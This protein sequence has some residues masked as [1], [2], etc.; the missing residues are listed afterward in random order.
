[1]LAYG[2]GGRGRVYWLLLPAPRGGFFRETF[3]AVNAA[4]RRAAATA[5]R[6]ARLIDLE[7]VF[8]PGGRY[9]ATMRV[10]GRRV[11]VRQR[12]GVHLSAAGAALAA[13]IVAR[14]LRAERILP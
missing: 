4:L 11:R 3:P 14:T 7:R 13:R 6:Y 9:R 12:D 10:N 1:M 5:R 2:R 8:T